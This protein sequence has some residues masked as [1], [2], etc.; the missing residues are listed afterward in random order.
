MR[1]LILLILSGLATAFKRRLLFAGGFHAAHGIVRNYKIILLQAG[2]S[3]EKSVYFP[4]T[5]PSQ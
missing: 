5:K 4:T 1:V 2:K 3:N